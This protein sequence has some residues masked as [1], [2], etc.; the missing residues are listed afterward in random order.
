MQKSLADPDWAITMLSSEPLPGFDA[1]PMPRK[2]T[3]SLR[4]RKVSRPAKRSRPTRP[5]SPESGLPDGFYR[6]LVWNLRNGV[7]AITREG[8]I[9]VMN[10]NAYGILGL[11]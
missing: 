5:P 2:S 8:L 9:A 11:K 3:R 1:A 7:V 10:D 4:A 6:D